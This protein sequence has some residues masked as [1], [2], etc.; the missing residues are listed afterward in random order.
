VRI[1][2]PA[3]KT[4]G[5]KVKT[6][7]RHALIPGKGKEGFVTDS[8]KFVGREEAGKIAKKARQVKGMKSPRLHSEN[9]KG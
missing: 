8:G 6:G 1:K 7:K 2:S 5:G 3:V 9:L 4:P